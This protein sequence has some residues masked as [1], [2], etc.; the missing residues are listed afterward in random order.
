[1]TNCLVYYQ[2]VFQLKYIFDFKSNNN[3]STLIKTTN[4]RYFSFT[5]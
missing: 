5:G 3:I 1:M 4:D 2:Y